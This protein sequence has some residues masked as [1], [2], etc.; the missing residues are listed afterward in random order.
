MNGMFLHFYGIED[1]RIDECLKKLRELHPNLI[2]TNRERIAIDIPC[3]QPVV[4]VRVAFEAESDLNLFSTCKKAQALY[5]L[6]AADE[7]SG[8]LVILQPGKPPQKQTDGTKLL[9]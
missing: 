8:G 7:P 2:E 9:Q 4:E 6:Y 5:M 1:S 3:P